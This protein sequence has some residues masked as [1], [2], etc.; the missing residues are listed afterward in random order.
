MHATI[1]LRFYQNFYK[2]ILE[3]KE[4]H[5]K[6]VHDIVVI[7]VLIWQWTIKRKQYHDVYAIGKR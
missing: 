6:L 3:Q 7:I 4:R 2:K 1:Y 5:R